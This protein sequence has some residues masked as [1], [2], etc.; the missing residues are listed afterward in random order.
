M[1]IAVNVCLFAPYLKKTHLLIYCG[2]YSQRFPFSKFS[3]VTELIQNG[4]NSLSPLKIL[5]TTP[6]YDNIKQAFCTL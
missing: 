3:Y 2:K 1:F 4:L 6:H 5:Q